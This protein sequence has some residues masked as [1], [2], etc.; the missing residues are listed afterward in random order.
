MSYDESERSRRR[1][2]RSSR[3]SAAQ[4]LEDDNLLS[5]ILL[6]L[7][8]DPSSLPRASLVSKRWLGLISDPGFSRRF[9]LHHRRNPPLLGFFVPF[10]FKPAMDPPNRVPDGYF[11]LCLDR[12][13]GGGIFMPMGSRHGLLLMYQSARYQLLVWDPFNVDLHRLA[14]P[15]EWL[16]APFKGAVFCGA[17]DIQ[18][19]RL[20]LVSTETDKQQHTR[21][22]ARVYSS[23]TAIWGDRISTP[24][25]S[26]LPT[27]SHMYFT[28]SVLVGHS[29]YWLFDDTSAKT[30][31]LDGILEFDLEKQILAVKPVPVGIPKEN[32]CR[33]QVMRAEGGGLGILFLS[34][35]SAQLWKVETDCDGAASW[36]LGRTVELYKLLSIDSRKKR[37][38]HQCIVGFAEYNNVLLLRTPTDLFMIQLEPLQF[39]K[40]SKTKKWAHYHPFESVYAA[41]TSIGGGHDGA[42]LLH[43]T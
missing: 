19:F 34:N 2:R 23:E 28:I 22:I 11:S 7:P 39:K 29:L 12:E 38:W 30:L 10:N 37:K 35:F 41:G 27:K 24:L 4:P 31:L 9:L 20:V 40:V 32:M 36:V 6:R 17:G 15:P 3:S 33:F 21:A 25:P 43:N 42:E 16:K 26:K 1:R 18:H 13:N 8:P 14:V 5:E